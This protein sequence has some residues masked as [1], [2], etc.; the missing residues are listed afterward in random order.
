MYTRENRNNGAKNQKQIHKNG[1]NWVFFSWHTFFA[2]LK[3]FSFI[4]NFRVIFENLLPY[5][6]PLHIFSSRLK[7]CVIIIR[8]HLYSI[9]EK[10]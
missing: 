3:P 7:L 5:V 10:K 2:S 9:D 6:F 1:K 4:L 8:A